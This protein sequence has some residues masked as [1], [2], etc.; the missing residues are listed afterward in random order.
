MAH[1]GPFIQKSKSPFAEEIPSWSE[2]WSNRP[3]TPLSKN[4]TISTKA[5]KKKL[6][7]FEVFLTYNNNILLIIIIIIIIVR[8]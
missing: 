4:Y 1:I 6:L 2:C 7:L 3:T 5:C 8:I